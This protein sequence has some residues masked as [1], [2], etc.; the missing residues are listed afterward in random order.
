MSLVENIKEACRRNRITVK[1]MER[2]AGLPEH[3]TYKWD[4]TDPGVKRVK[5]AADVLHTTLDE[6]MRE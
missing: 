4:K 1:E 5:R 3:S 2:R 6:L